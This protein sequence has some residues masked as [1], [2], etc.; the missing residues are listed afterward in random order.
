MTPARKETKNARTDGELRIIGGQWRGRKLRFPSLPGLR[1]SPDRVRETL[2]N[3]LAPEISGA[4]CLD[5]FAGSGALG[6]ESLSRGAAFCQFLDS[7]TLAAEFIEAHL[8]LLS[9]RDANVQAADAMQWLQQPRA[10]HGLQKAE[11]QQKPSAPF[12]MVFLDPPFRQGLL[13]RCCSLLEENG[14]LAE[15][16]WIYIEAAGDEAPPV[17]PI[18]WQLHRDK[19][20]GQVA[21]RLY[22]R[23]HR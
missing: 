17:V 1:P 8:T 10:Q 18:T 6:L 9:C 12:N 11:L 14:W 21:Y 5:L 3:W 23:E 15:R 22:L 7:A 4:K 20:A 16:A 2:F 13:D 19:R